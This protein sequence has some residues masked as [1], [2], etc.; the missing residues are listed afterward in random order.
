[1]KRSYSQIAFSF[2][3]ALAGATSWAGYETHF[4]TPSPYTLGAT[5]IGSNGWAISGGSTSAETNAVVIRAPWDLSESTNVLKLKKATNGDSNVRLMNSSFA[6]LKGKV[7][8]VAGMAFDFKLTEHKGTNT[9]VS[10]RDLYAGNGPISFGF[11]HTETGGLYYRGTGGEIV[12]LPKAEIKMNAVYTFHL[13]IDIEAQLFDLSVTGTKADN[14]AFSFTVANLESG[15]FT[16]Q[17]LSLIFLQQTGNVNFTGYISSLD[18]QAI[19]EPGVAQLL[20]GVGACGILVV[21]GKR[22]SGRAQLQRNAR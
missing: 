6:P 5:A 4:E 22:A 9:T 14:T 8:V 17:E 12:I 11:T 19:P 20:L 3:F 13:S 16:N 15:A 1:M 2:V 18:V 7:E 21:F 10:F